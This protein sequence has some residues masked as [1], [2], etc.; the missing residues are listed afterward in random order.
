[1]ATRTSSARVAALLIFVCLAVSGL[2]AQSVIKMPKNKYTPEQ[3]VK[4]GLEAAGEVR[5]QYPIIKDETIARYLTALGD[6]LVVA[7][8][9][10]FK[11]PVYQYSFTPVNLKEINA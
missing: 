9:S 5:Q 8:P 1:M 7:A 2:M 3:D 11:Q 10:E 6:R 4:L